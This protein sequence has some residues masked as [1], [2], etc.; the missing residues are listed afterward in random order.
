MSDVLFGQELVIISLGTIALDVADL[1]SLRPGSEINFE[2]NG[3]LD[4]S[5]IVA[6]CEWAKV[7]VDISGSAGKLRITELNV[8]SDSVN[9]TNLGNFHPKTSIT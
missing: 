3:S 9:S 4:G 8:I 5:L 6:G 2:H 7:K 1:I